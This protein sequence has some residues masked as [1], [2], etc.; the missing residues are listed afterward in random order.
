MALPVEAGPFAWGGELKLARL[1]FRIEFD[2]EHAVGP[3]KIRLLEA[4]RDA[5]SISEAGRSLGMSY[6]RAWLLVADMNACFDRP[7]V[8]TQ[9]GGVRGGGATVT[10]FGATLIETYREIERQSHKASARQLVRL[11]TARR[12]VSRKSKSSS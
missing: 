12:Q 8:A 3:G 11:E 1:I 10:P 4:I 9:L 5:G 2:D 6:R 7:V